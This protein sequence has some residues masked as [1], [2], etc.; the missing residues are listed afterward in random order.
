MG[1]SLRNDILVEL[2]SGNVY[3]IACKNIFQNSGFLNAKAFMDI[4]D[5]FEQLARNSIQVTDENDDPV[6][7]QI[8]SQD[9]PF[10]VVSCQSIF[11]FYKSQTLDFIQIKIECSFSFNR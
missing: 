8:I 1:K 10:Y 11:F 9:S 2:I 6:T 3:C 5:V 4:S 7:S